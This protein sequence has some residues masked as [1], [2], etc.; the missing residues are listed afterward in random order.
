VPPM[1]LPTRRA[2]FGSAPSPSP[3]ALSS[4]ELPL[5]F[6]T[7][8]R[9]PTPDVNDLADTGA[10]AYGIFSYTDHHPIIWV[11]LWDTR[12][13]ARLSWVSCQAHNPYHHRQEM[14]RNPNHSGPG[15]G[16][17]PISTPPH[18]GMGQAHGRNGAIDDHLPCFR[19]IWQFSGPRLRI[20]RCCWASEGPRLRVMG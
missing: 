19:S 18:A 16:D 15:L 6:S 1:P 20:S 2:C 11:A 5:P 8:S 3:W 17:A 12:R 14:Q 13:P 9:F 7:T 4:P 10:V